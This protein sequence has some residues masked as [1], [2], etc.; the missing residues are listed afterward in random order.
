MK[1]QQNELRFFLGANTPQGFVSHFDELLKPDDGWRTFA[2]KG[3]PG[4]G[5][6]T[7]MK[8][9][10]SHFA[11]SHDDI[12]LIYC[13]SDTN[14][15]DAV[16]IPGLKLSI[17]DATP[18]H[19]IE[20]KYPGAVES[21]V[22]LSACWDTAKLRACGSEIISLSRSCNTRHEHCCRFLNAAAILSGDTYRIALDAV[23]TRKL[24]AY[25]DRIAER[26]FRPLKQRGGRESIRLLS[27]VTNRGVHTFT[28]T[29]NN[30]CER[31]FVITDDYGAVS[32]LLLHKLRSKALAAG[33]DIITSYCPL[34][35]F[36]KIEH[37]LIPGLGLGF[38]VSNRAH[39]LGLLLSPHR[40]INSKRFMDIAELK[41]SKQRTTFNWK[42]ERQMIDQAHQLL[43]EAKKL[44]DELE[45]YYIAATDFNMVEDITQSLITEM[46]NEKP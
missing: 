6:S 37:L 30:L 15:V 35:P 23:D 42:A 26:E 16:I 36:D 8:R 18:P 14:S 38:V 32:R 17:C 2:I 11:E 43:A 25:A 28:D 21:L 27:A 4:C 24:A 22:N 40:I 20:P 29:I 7:L 31:I 12:Q 19:V 41:Q 46:E 1:P 45:G 5:K 33:Y 3:G 44:H 13:S 34:G 10:Y 9:V 39:D